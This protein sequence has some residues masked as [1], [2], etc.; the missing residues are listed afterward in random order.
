MEI[1]QWDEKLLWKSTL[2]KGTEDP[3]ILYHCKFCPVINRPIVKEFQ[4]W[5]FSSKQTSI[6]LRWEY[7]ST[8]GLLYNLG[9]EKNLHN[10][11]NGPL[12]NLAATKACSHIVRRLIFLSRTSKY[13]ISLRR[14]FTLMRKD[15]YTTG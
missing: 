11:T 5:T 13:V 9:V 8:N 10:G 7:N 4:S 3:F 12:Y 15:L 6:S 1:L 2:K 14:G